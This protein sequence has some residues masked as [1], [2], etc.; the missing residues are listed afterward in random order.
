MILLQYY[1]RG[2]NMNDMQHY[3]RDF[4]RARLDEKVDIN[5]LGDLAAKNELWGNEKPMMELYAHATKII[6]DIKKLVRRQS[7]E[8]VFLLERNKRAKRVP[9]VEEIIR[10]YTQSDSS[11]LFNKDLHFLFMDF[12]GFSVYTPDKKYPLNGFPN[13]VKED[14]YTPC[15][16]ADYYLNEKYLGNTER[17]L[18]LLPHTENRFESLNMSCISDVVETALIRYVSGGKTFIRTFNVHGIKICNCEEHDEYQLIV[19]DPEKQDGLSFKKIPKGKIIEYTIKDV[20]KTQ[21]YQKP[22]LPYSYRKPVAY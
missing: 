9:Y 12:K 13:P 8:N 2:F 4:V 19:S 14:K 16:V 1:Y 6:N 21:R 17:H 10:R 18:F 3:D 20:L 22:I 5:L 15:S 7:E 11:V